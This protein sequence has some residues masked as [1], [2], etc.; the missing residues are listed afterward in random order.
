MIL[1]Y[2]KYGGIAAVVVLICGTF[3]HLGGNA[4]RAVSE[5]AHAAQLAA[6]VKTLETQRDAALTESNRRQGIIDAYDKAQS[7][8]DPV[9]A[10][11]AHRV[12]LYTTGPGCR[13]VPSTAALASGTPAPAS[14]A[15][16]D[17]I[18]QRLSE[19]TQATFDAADADA[20]QM[21]AMIQFASPAPPPK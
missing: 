1:S 17:A 12:Y 5:A 11:L 6:V 10:G 15:P 16:G 7:V 9:V 2:L 3:Y 21:R 20:E 14:V 13:V 18:A 19:L 4:S 8:P